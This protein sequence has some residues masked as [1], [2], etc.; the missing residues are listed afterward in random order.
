MMIL[1]LLTLQRPKGEIFSLDS[2][3]KID[4]NCICRHAR[5]PSESKNHF[6]FPPKIQYIWRICSCI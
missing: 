4:S 5:D 3:T 6:F 2:Y 1:K